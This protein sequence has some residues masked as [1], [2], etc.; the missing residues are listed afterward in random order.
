M[1]NMG[2]KIKIFKK[3]RGKTTLFFFLQKI[4]TTN[5]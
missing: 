5:E 1:F 2:M 3:K 4:N